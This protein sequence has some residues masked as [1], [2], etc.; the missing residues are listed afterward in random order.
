VKD[1]Q[2]NTYIGRPEKI[3]GPYKDLAAVN[4]ALK[5]AHWHPTEYEF[6]RSPGECDK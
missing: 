3:Y 6:W 2:G 1:K 5:A 4:A